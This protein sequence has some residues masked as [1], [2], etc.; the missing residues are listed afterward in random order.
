MIAPRRWVEA[1]RRKIVVSKKAKAVKNLTE[2]STSAWWKKIEP[3]LKIW[4][5]IPRFDVWLRTFEKAAPLVK[6]EL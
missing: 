5:P 2:V 4:F 6:F 3:I 1:R